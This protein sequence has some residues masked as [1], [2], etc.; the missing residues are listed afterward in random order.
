[1]QAA[2]Q[3]A[4]SKTKME[5]YYNSSVTQVSSQAIWSTAAT[6]QVTPGMEANLDPNGKDRTKLQ[7]RLEKEHTNLKIAKEMNSRGH[8]TFVILKSVIYTKF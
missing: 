2:I 5:K 6:T 4:K 7:N 1:E 8:G 3:E